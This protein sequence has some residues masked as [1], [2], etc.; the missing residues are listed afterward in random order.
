M[1]SVTMV[2]V[3]WQVFAAATAAGATGPTE[4]LMAL[5]ETGTPSLSTIPT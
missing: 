1:S 2:S 4:N 5:V 3:A